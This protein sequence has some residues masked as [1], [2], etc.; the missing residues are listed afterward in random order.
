MR[1]DQD[2]KLPM[3]SALAK[4]LEEQNSTRNPS[5]SRTSYSDAWILSDLLNT[6]T[7]GA[8]PMRILNVRHNRL[9]PESF[10]AIP[11]QKI[12]LRLEAAFMAGA[13]ADFWTLLRSSALLRLPEQ[14]HTPSPAER[15]KKV[16]NT[17]NRPS[18]FFQPA[19]PPMIITKMDEQKTEAAPSAPFP[20]SDL[21][22]LRAA[23]MRM[24]SRNH[25]PH[26]YPSTRNTSARE[27]IPASTDW[28][29]LPEK[30]RFG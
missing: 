21:E 12:P 8:F 16:L 11:E 1:E 22:Q 2:P 6:C 17:Q 18:R 25:A 3:E 5:I 30:R 26:L 23:R 19:T 29:V 14:K 27:T 28:Q 13:A 15:L 24:F 9:R 20:S 4:E 10:M 7:T